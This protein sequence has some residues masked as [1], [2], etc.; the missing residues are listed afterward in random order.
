[1][2]KFDNIGNSR[3]SIFYPKRNYFKINKSW[4]ENYSEII[5][6]LKFNT[7]YATIAVLKVKIKVSIPF[8]FQFGLIIKIIYLEYTF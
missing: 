5:I 3:L 2:P 7:I 1:M 8:Q 6:Y 4:I